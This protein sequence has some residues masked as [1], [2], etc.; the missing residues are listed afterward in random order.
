MAWIRIDDHFDEHPKHSQVGPLAWGVWLAGLAY[1]NRNQT[2]GFIPRG[3]AKTLASFEVVDADGVIWTLG[4]TSGMSGADIDSEWIIGFLVEATLWDE[5]PGGYSV[6]DY[7]D[8]QPTREQIAELTE[9]KKAAGK[10]GG[11]ASAQA[12][13][14]ANG[15]AKSNPKPNPNTNTKPKDQTLKTLAPDGAF[16][17]FWKNYPTR[18]NTSSKGNKKATQAEWKKLSPE[19]RSAALA[20]LATYARA[21]NGYPKDAERYLKGEEWEGLDNVVSLPES[22]YQWL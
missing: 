13:A 8:Y 17:E 15:Q 2:D 20:S 18:P 3:K 7:S 9:K 10:A 6:H 16:E 14:S 22:E 11:K 4:R 12:R 21:K 5:V 19:Q 1:C